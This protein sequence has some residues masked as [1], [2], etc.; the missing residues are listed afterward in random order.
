MESLAGVG[1]VDADIGILRIEPKIAN[2]T[3]HVALGVLRT[4]AAEM[5]AEAEERRRRRA[6][7]PALD[8]Q[9]A[10]QQEAAAAQDFV[11]HPR[12]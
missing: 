10:H 2:V 6:Q 4:G 1:L 11:A 9:A 7:A 8:R 5:R 3:Q 12:S